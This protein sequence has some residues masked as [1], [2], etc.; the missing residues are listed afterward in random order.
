M[1]QGQG[2][3]EDS[4]RPTRQEAS[5]LLATGRVGTFSPSRLRGGG[6]CFLSR[7]EL[8]LIY[9][10]KH[11]LCG[12]DYGAKSRGMGSGEQRGGHSM[13]PSDLCKNLMGSSK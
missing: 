6:K 5:D 8:V 3:K 11:K 9:V 12:V 1:L 7:V 2:S 4:R 10:C 13:G